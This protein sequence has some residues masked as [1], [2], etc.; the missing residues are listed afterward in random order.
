[1]SQGVPISIQGKQIL[2]KMM[3]PGVA[4]DMMTMRTMG[5]TPSVGVSSEL[6][7]LPT[8]F[9]VPFVL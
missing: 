4:G 6:V 1:M 8:G 9:R 3:T 2:V 7:G 5:M